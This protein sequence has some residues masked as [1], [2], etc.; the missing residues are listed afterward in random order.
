MMT[1]MMMM[2]GRVIIICFWSNFAHFLFFCKEKSSTTDKYIGPDV[3]CV[4]QSRLAIAFCTLGIIFLLA[5]IVAIY[6]SIKYLTQRKIY[7]H[8]QTPSDSNS[9]RRSIFS[10]SSSSNNFSQ[11]SLGDIDSKLFAYG[12]VYWLIIKIF[13]CY[14]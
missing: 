2:V 5:V 3:L 1:T 13:H 11:S 6:C 4:S 14:C 10:T 8:R 7:L 9:G 12:R